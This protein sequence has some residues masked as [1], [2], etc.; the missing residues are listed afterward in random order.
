[1]HDVAVERAELAAALQEVEQVGAHLHQLA[2]AARRAVEPAKQLLPPRLRGKVQ[3]AG[4][5][6][7]VGEE[8]RMEAW[9]GVESVEDFTV[10]HP[11]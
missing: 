10:E 2:G 5:F 11:R 1:M 7:G 8:T 6:S 4:G 3:V 9:V